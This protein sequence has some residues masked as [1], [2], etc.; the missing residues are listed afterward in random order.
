MDAGAIERSIKRI[1]HEILERNPGD[2]PLGLIGIHTRG[3]PLAERLLSFIEAIEPGRDHHPVGEL[4][5]SFHRDDTEDNLPVPKSTDIPFDIQDQRIILVDD[6]FF[7]RP[8]HPS[9]HERPVGLGA[10][11]QHPVGGFGGP[12]A[13]GIADSRGLRG[14]K[15]PHRL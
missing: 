13:S 15:Y 3:V 8:E 2:F 5:I 9:R 7:Y 6:V 4:D 10:D 11:G 12:R 1:A 14:K